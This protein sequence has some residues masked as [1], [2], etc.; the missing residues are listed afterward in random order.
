MAQPADTVPFRIIDVAQK[1][2]RLFNAY[3]EKDSLTRSRIFA[4]SL[5]QP[6]KAFWSGYMG[7][8]ENFVRWANKA[9][10]N[11]QGFNHRNQK[12]NGEKLL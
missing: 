6:Y 5:Y 3:K 7:E 8:E 9:L 11:L 4:D 12:I 2:I 10:T 1:E